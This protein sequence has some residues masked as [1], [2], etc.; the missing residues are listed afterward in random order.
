M[1]DL[2]GGTDFN[3][4]I[5]AWDVSNVTNMDGMFLDCKVF[6]QDISDWD[7]SNVKNIKKI[8]DMCPIKEKHKPKFK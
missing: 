4:D 5:S 8:F 2:F 6:N 1:S 3:G 7:I